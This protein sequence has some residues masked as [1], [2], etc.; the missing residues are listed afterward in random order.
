MLTATFIL[1]VEGCPTYPNGKSRT[2]DARRLS[3]TGADIPSLGQAKASNPD[4]QPR[5]PPLERPTILTEHISNSS[6]FRVTRLSHSRG[7]TFCANF[8]DRLS[9]SSIEPSVCT[10]VYERT[11]VIALAHAS[12]G[13][14]MRNI[15]TSS[16]SNVARETLSSSR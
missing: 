3:N 12:V 13:L 5:R 2:R 6:N 4:R 11:R 1:I 14:V 9:S 8:Q 15:V 16:R 7:Y 10:I